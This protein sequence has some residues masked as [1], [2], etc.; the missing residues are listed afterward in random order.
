MVVV[1][2]SATGVGEGIA[3][4]AAF[5]GARVLVH[6][7]P[8]ERDAGDHVAQA[9]GGHFVAG[10][11]ADPAVPRRVI[12]EAIGHFGRLDGLVNNAAVSWRGGVDSTAEF[13]DLVMAINARA[14]MLMIE[15]A[16]PHLNPGASIVNIGSVNGHRAAA[17]LLPYGMSKAALMN[18]TRSLSGVLAEKGIR[19]NGLNL[20]WTLTPNERKLLM[21]TA[22]W[23]EDWPETMGERM[24]FKRLMRPEDVAPTACLLLSEEASMVT[25]QMWDFDQ[26]S[27][28][29]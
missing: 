22:G 10:D 27:Q 2:G 25:G 17:D 1:T 8:E 29:R 7:R 9:I 26:R 21:E 3:R 11:L 24:P 19:I 6:G 20:G 28:V 12:D 13:F 5:E 18:L 14:P 23:S 15:A 4:R 16:L